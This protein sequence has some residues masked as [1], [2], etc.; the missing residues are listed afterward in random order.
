MVSEC[1]QMQVVHQNMT[2]TYPCHS[3]LLCAPWIARTQKSLT[4]MLATIWLC[5]RCLLLQRL[6]IDVHHPLANP[7]ISSS[8]VL[9]YMWIRIHLIHHPSLFQPRWPYMTPGIKKSAKRLWHNTPCYWSRLHHIHI[10]LH[11]KIFHVSIMLMNKFSVTQYL[12]LAR[13]ILFLFSAYFIKHSCMSS[14]YF[15]FTDHFIRA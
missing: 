2:C 3:V 1:N 8:T 6:K 14:E 4:V 10:S 15:C 9:I 5:L 11:A 13:I 7:I 12:S